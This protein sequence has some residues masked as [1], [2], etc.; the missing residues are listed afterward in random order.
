MHMDVCSRRMRETACYT[1]AASVCTRTLFS[2]SCVGSSFPCGCRPKKPSHDISCQKCCLTCQI[3][4]SG[5]NVYDT[6]IGES[7]WSL[8]LFFLFFS[9]LPWPLGIKVLGEVSP[10]STF[11]RSSIQPALYP[12]L[13]LLLLTLLL[14]FLLQGFPIC[15]IRR[16]NPSY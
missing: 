14:L 10:G 13:L 6:S 9:F 2:G 7:F 1:T 16:K 15:E 8:L 11:I 3:E 4:R 12:L 5:A